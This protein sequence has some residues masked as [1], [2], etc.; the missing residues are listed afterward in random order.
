[1]TRRAERGFCVCVG[2]IDGVGKTTLLQAHAREREP[3]DVQLTGSSIVRGLIAPATVEDFDRWTEARREEVRGAAIAALRTRRG[4]AVGRLLVD[5]HFTLR[6]RVSGRVEPIFTAE[7]RGF[8]D[9][10]LLVEAPAELVA[11]WRRGD[12]RARR[13]ESVAGIEEHLV[14][15]RMEGRRLASEMGVPFAVITSTV[16]SDR[17]RELASFLAAYAALGGAA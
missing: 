4:E 9:A 15:E 17:L 8:Y 14:A 5:G 7:D 13:D 6:H 11:S 10:L 16:V 2:G 3:R 1:M 12:T